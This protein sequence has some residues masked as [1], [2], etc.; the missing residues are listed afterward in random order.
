M[1]FFRRPVVCLAG[2]TFSFFPTLGIA[3]TP[4]GSV[5]AQQEPFITFPDAQPNLSTGPA[6]EIVRLRVADGYFVFVQMLGGDVAIIAEGKQAFDTLRSTTA[7]QSA[8]AL[9]L[10][11]AAG[12]DPNA[13]PAILIADEARQASHRTHR[14]ITLTTRNSAAPAPPVQGV[15]GLGLIGSLCI[16]GGMPTYDYF[17][18][19]WTHLFYV[20]GVGTLAEIGAHNKEGH[21]SWNNGPANL[22]LGATSAGAAVVCFPDGESD[23]FNARITVQ[24]YYGNGLWID[25]FAI[26]T[27]YEG[28]AY[29]YWFKGLVVH[30]IRVLIRD[31]RPPADQ[32]PPIGPFY[33]GG[34]Y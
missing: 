24:E 17:V 9:D 14:P 30:K 11:L 20:P 1:T 22:N 8:T 32:N 19:Q 21:G 12:G 31:E 29:G 6:K 26:P 27:V 15:S 13:A 34:A 18:L 4:T 33:W 25:L 5:A 28:T 7:E 2:L 16:S 23:A 3:Q 10:Y